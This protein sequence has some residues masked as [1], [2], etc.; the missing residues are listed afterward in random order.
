MQRHHHLN[1]IIARAMSAANIPATKEPVGLLRSDGK[2]PDGLTLIPWQSGRPLTWNVTVYHTMAESYLPLV[3]LTAGGVAEQ[4]AAR[5]EDKYAELAKS[6]LFQPLSFETMG[7]INISGQ[8]FISDL[9]RRICDLS[10][11]HI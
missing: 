1:E 11:I 9:G 3:A 10:L 2:R 6:F 4:A 5:K 8:S 7:P